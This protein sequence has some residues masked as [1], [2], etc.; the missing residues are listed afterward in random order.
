MKQK[1][2]LALLIV[3]VFVVTAFPVLSA[4][5]LYKIA[6]LPFDDGSIQERWWDGGH[7][8]VGKGIADE[9]ITE[10]LQT[11]RFR[12]IE[13]EQI[14]KIIAEQ[15]FG[16]SDRVDTRSAA[17]LGKILG[18]QFLVMGRV[19]EFSL[20]STG[21]SGLSLKN[22]IGLGVKSTNATVA[23]DARLVDTSSAEIITSVTGKGNKRNT[24]LSVAVDWQAIAM[25]SDEFRKTNLGLAMRE[26][27]VAAS[28]ELADKAYNSGYT[29]AQPEKL[30]GAVAYVSGNKVIINLGSTAGLKPGNVLIVSQ[31]LEV[32]KDPATG[33]VIDEV[34]EV[35]AEI[36]VTEVKDKSAT[37]NVLKQLSSK[38]RLAVGNKVEQK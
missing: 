22:G 2:M 29:P 30:S 27:V 33:N 32:V 14:D 36:E 18:V 5:Q 1:L 26:A 4:E 19:T 31:V 3:M 23:I 37:C 13:R 7:W 12:L 11:K 6:V 25:G 21:V 17:K 15:D 28:K 8:D 20:K 16:Q 9:F 38:S 35:I 24:N 34:T 10:L